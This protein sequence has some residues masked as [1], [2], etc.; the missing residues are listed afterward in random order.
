MLNALYGSVV[1]PTAVF[2][3]RRVDFNRPGIRT[4]S[5]AFGEDTVYPR[6]LAA[7]SDDELARL[8]RILDP[9]E[10]SAVLPAEQL[11][12]RFLLIDERRG[13]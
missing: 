12:G 8:S 9:G 7:G 5:A 11:Q 13:R 2:S 4:R 10:A 1:V 6:P 3:Q